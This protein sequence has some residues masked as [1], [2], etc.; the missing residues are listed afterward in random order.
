MI[1]FIGCPPELCLI[2]CQAVLQ[3]GGQGRVVGP[4]VLWA[5]GNG[6]PLVG[7]DQHLFSVEHQLAT[8]GT[9]RVEKDAEQREL[10]VRKAS[11]GLT[12]R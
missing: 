8:I 10:S 2:L 3:K 4:A 12:R 5:V 6:A 11:A 1:F 7:A 9:G